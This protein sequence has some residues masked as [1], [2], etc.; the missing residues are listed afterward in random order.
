MRSRED[1]KKW[2]LAT[3]DYG[4][5]LQ[6]D[7]NAILGYNE[8]FNNGIVRHALDLKNARIFQ[9]LNS[10]NLT[11]RNIKKLGLQ[12][13]I[14]EKLATQV[15]ASKLNEDQLTKTILMQD[16]ISNIEN[17]LE[18]LRKPI[19]VNDISDDDRWRRRWRHRR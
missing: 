3:S 17:R 19:N 16:Q 15:K 6:E 7:L 18:E 5:E 9:N 13:P 2:L 8:K 4:N 14:I 11:Y 1:F 10:L 12:N